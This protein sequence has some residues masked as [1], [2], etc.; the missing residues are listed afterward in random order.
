MI[1]SL[2]EQNVKEAIALS[3]YVLEDGRVVVATKGGSNV[4]EWR[5]RYGS[6]TKQ[7]IDDPHSMEAVHLPSKG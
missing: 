7:F 4:D 2:C 1:D 5:K 3:F 6:L